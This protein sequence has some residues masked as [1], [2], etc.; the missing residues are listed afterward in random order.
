MRSRH[1][2]LQKTVYDAAITKGYVSKQKI[3]KYFIQIRGGG[4][5]VQK[6]QLHYN[7]FFT[8]IRTSAEEGVKLRETEQRLLF[9]YLSLN[10]FS[11][12]VKSIVFCAEAI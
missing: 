12:P 4:H 2:S 10:N 7:N 9:A 6:Q 3:I 8:A 5:V 1:P 11:I